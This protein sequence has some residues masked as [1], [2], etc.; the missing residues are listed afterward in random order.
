[1]ADL[2]TEGGN[3]ISG[4]RA[5]F[6]LNSQVIGWARNFSMSESTEYIPIEVLNN[7]EV[8]HH[9]PIAYRVSA[10][11]SMIRILNSS[12]KS[13]GFVPKIGTD[14]SSHIANILALPDMVCSIAD[15]V[16]N[17][18]LATITNVRIS[19]TSFSVDSR[20]VMGMDCTFAAIRVLDES[21]V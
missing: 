16:T 20:G 14:P 6:S 7:I 11:A 9:V 13:L 15:T 18:T 17:T 8:A 21:E 4:A 12:F 3:I 10:S 5:I 1:M 19:D 2:A